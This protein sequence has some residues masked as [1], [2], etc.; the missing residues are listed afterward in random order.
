MIYAKGTTCFIHEKASDTPLIYDI[1]R[2]SIIETNNE[3]TIDQ[4]L[5]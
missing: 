2:E 5:H 1:S 3:D 4:C